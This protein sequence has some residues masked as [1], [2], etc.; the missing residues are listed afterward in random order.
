MKG[1]LVMI[2]ILVGLVLAVLIGGA[3]AYIIKEK[4]KGTVCIGCPSA[5]TCSAKKR[6]GSAGC[7]CCIDAAAVEKRH[8]GE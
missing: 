2:D 7:S 3:I 4:K 5:G 8:T 1:V 6:P